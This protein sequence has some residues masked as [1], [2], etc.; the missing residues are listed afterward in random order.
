MQAFAAE[1][2]KLL[3]DGFEPA[4]AA[5]RSADPAQVQRMLVQEIQHRVRICADPLPRAPL[6]GEPWQAAAVARAAAAESLRQQ[7][8]ALVKAVAVFSVG[9]APA[10]G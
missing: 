1:N 9:P 2:V 6:G 8:T 10:Y 4:L 3:K 7:A 5:L